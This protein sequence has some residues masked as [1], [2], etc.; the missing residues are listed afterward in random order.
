IPGGKPAKRPHAAAMTGIFHTTRWSQVLA[1]GSQDQAAASAALAWL[2]ERQWEPLR[3]V[4][5]RLGV[6]GDEAED[7]VQD[8]CCR[9]IERRLELG[10]LEPSGGQFRAWLLT[11]FRNYLHDWRAHRR[12][13]KRGGAAD[14]RDVLTVEPTAAVLDPEFDRD[15][16]EAILARALDRLGAEQAGTP[17]RF[18]ALRQLLGGNATPDS[19]TTIGAGIGLSEAAVKVAIH[20]MRQ[21]LRELLRQEITETLAEPTP[22]AIDDELAALAAALGGM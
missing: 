21:R 3:R 8:F 9:L 11:V 15:W 14:H 2:C 19:Y 6:S 22:Q 7:L 5:R 1:A 18:T 17:G 4:A 12:A 13:A 20:R 16:A 10:A